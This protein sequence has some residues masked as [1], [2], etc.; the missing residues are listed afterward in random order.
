[1]NK[2]ILFFCFISFILSKSPYP[3]EKNVY[4]LSEHTF[5]LAMREFK[6][7]IVLF[8]DP[9]TQKSQEFLL[10]FEKMASNLKKE[11]FIFAKP[12]RVKYETIASHYDIVA[13][14]SVTLFKKNQRIMY[15]GKLDIDEIEKW[16]K[17]KTK[18]V[19]TSI[20]SKR[21]FENYKKNNKVFLA[22]FGSD[23]KA[24]NELIL[25]ERKVDE[26]PIVTIGSEQL[27][28]ENVKQEK[29]ETFVIFKNF[30]NKKNVFKG[31]ITSKNLIKFINIYMY[32]KV[33]ECNK[34][35]SHVIYNRREPAL[36]IF[37]TKSERHYNDSLNLFNYMWKQWKQIK[38]KIRLLVCDIR[39]PSAAK[40][41]EYCNIT[42]KTIPKVFIAHFDS[43][44]PSRYEM[45][46]GINE[47][48]M[49]RL[50]S[51]YLKGELKPFI[52]SEKVP[53]DNIGDLFILV[54]NNYNKE[55]LN[56]DKDVLIY[57]ISP[58]CEACKEFEPK[59]A[60]L[61]KK[62]K[63]HNPKLLIAIMDS[64]KN[65]V[66]DYV[67]HNFPTILFYPGNAK[68]KEPLEFNIDG[69][70]KTLLKLIKLNAYTKI[71]TDEETDL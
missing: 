70:I 54:G 29:N 41:V 50:L 6:Y 14:P 53:K 68:D 7:L 65:D 55:V 57:F 38:K 28:R 71:I 1:M 2:N 16:I 42:E 31:E 48:N 11:N 32:P 9:E 39:D 19:F 22:Y 62:L 44:V 25:A 67:I 58:W 43:E 13:S 64:T 46:G 24:I 47:E 66:E 37:S 52:R 20:T 61:A 10:E 40:L 8:L 34:E 12:D 63:E 35:Y 60:K 23:E 59:L 49:M 4:V 30:G 21:E 27:I 17:E 69:K 3:K 51:K 15:E 56:N 36:I 33:L 45:N 18:I 5:G 26:I